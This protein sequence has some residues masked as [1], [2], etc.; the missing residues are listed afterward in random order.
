MYDN[1]DEL[2]APHPASPPSAEVFDRTV[3]VI[4]R[5]RRVR[6][7]A[8]IGVLTAACASG[9]LTILAFQAPHESIGNQ[10]G[11]PW[12]EARS[13]APPAAPPL[14]P[15][16]SAN[17][18]EWQALDAPENAVAGLYRKAGDLYLADADPAEAVRCYGNALSTGKP[19]DLEVSPQDS[20]LLMVIKQART[21]ERNECDK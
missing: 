17:E 1:L 10:T 13:I 9:L 21:K 15:A 12:E 4:R 14:R 18:L 16:P 5:Q 2:L 3:Q 6:Q 19:E 7:L 8:G 11:A 20:W